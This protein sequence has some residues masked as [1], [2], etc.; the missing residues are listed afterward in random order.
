MDG[1]K[2]SVLDEHIERTA[3]YM[4]ELIINKIVELADAYFVAGDIEQN[5]TIN[6]ALQAIA[7]VLEYNDK[8]RDYLRAMT[9]NRLKERRKAWEE[10]QKEIRERIKAKNGYKF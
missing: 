6:F 8:D 5:L 2:H 4:K 9:F 3:A 1:R 10:E 7:N